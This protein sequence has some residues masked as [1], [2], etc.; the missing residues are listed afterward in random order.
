MTRAGFKS[1]EELRRYSRAV[2]HAARHNLFTNGL[3]RAEVVEMMEWFIVLRFSKRPH[4][5]W[6]DPAAMVEECAVEVKP[7]ALECVLLA[8]KEG[9][10]P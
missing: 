8:E 9:P 1:A 10:L 3:M 2:I 7:L 5:E 6:T 4:T